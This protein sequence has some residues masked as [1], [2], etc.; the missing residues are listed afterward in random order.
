MQCLDILME[1]QNEKDNA[2]SGGITA[3]YK[4]AIKGRFNKRPFS[5]NEN[6]NLFEQR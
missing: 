5:Y 2:V 1:T 6:L 4:K 3:L